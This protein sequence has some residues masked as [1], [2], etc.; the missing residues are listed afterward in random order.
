[1]LV[2]HG[3]GV[4]DMLASDSITERKSSYLKYL[5]EIYQDDAVMGQLLL[6]FESILSP[7]ERTIDNIVSYID[8][9]ITPEHL[10]PWLASWL[11]L[12]LDPTWPEDRRRALIR[13]A[14][15]LYRWR[16]T[17]WGLATYLKIYTGS[18]PEILEYMEGILLDGDSKLGSRAQ[19]GSGEAWYHFTVL[20][21]V[22]EDS[23][24]LE[25]KVRRIIESQKP[26]HSTYTLRFT[27]GKQE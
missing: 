15:E 22:D 26:A 21:P 7:I 20:L 5:P 9:S 11:D 8:P 16:G 13:S 3:N 10:F 2:Y 18:E 24:I 6:L 23:N 27:H 4:V 25:N 14:A 12:S 1:V 17:R 19:L